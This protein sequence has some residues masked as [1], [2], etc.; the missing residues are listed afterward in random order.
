M[1]EYIYSKAEGF[2]D[3]DLRNICLKQL[4]DNK[5]KLMY[6]PAAQKNHHAELAGLLYHVKRMLM[7]AG[8]SL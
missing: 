6:Y 3:K 7:M 2:T 5:E 1:Y 8:K 4:E